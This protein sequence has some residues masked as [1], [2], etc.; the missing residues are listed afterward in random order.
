[1]HS[2]VARLR[3]RAISQATNST[4]QSDDGASS[5]PETP[6][7]PVSPVFP[8]SPDVPP[9]TAVD[10]KILPEVQ[11]L[12]DSFSV[13]DL[14]EHG[15]SPPPV[16]GRRSSSPALLSVHSLDAGP[17]AL[18][19]QDRSRSSSPAAHS[20]CSS[21]R[22]SKL[23]FSRFSR[24]LATSGV[25]STF[26][27]QHGGTSPRSSRID[28]Q[29]TRTGLTFG[30][31]DT[32]GIPRRSD[33]SGP[34]GTRTFGSS[35]ISEGRPSYASESSIALPATSYS[36]SF[37]HRSESHIITLDDPPHDRPP[38]PDTISSRQNSMKRSPTTQSSHSHSSHSPVA[39]VHTPLTTTFDLDF[40]SPQTFGQTSPLRLSAFTTS[41]N[42][43]ASA[44]PPP[45]MPPLSHPELVANMASRSQ[46]VLRELSTNIHSPPLRHYD[47]DL[48]PK[49]YPPRRRRKTDDDVPDENSVPFPE[50]RSR[51]SLRSYASLPKVRQLFQPDSRQRSK[52]S[53]PKST[54]SR[55]PSA[56]WNSQQATS[57]VLATN[58]ER[59]FGWPAE[60]SKEILR[61]SLGD[62]TIGKSR[63]IK[64]SLATTASSEPDII[65]RVRNVPAGSGETARPRLSLPSPHSKPTP[66][67]AQAEGEDKQPPTPPNGDKPLSW[68]PAGVAEV[69]RRMSAGGTS[70]LEEG[71]NHGHYSATLP[72]PAGSR[73][74]RKSILRH[75]NPNTQSQEAGPSSQQYVLS[76]PPRRS[77]ARHPARHSSE[78]A[79]PSVM[80]TPTNNKG[81]RK[82]EEIDITPPDQKNQHAKFILPVENKRVR[83]ISE[84]SGPP[85]AYQQRK[86]V[87]LSSSTSPAPTPG[88]SRPNSAQYGTADRNNPAVSPAVR[89]LSRAGSNRDGSTRSL[90][91]SI[92]SSIAPSVA[93]SRKG[94][95]RSP[96]QTS[97]PV[98]A[99][100]APHPPSLSRS[101]TYHMRDPRRPPRVHPT[102]WVPRVGSADEEGSSLHAW[103]FFAGFLLFPLWWI[104]SFLPIPE[105]RRVGYTDTE[106]GVT[107][108]DPQVEHDARTWRFRCRIMSVVALFTYI[109]FI[110]LVAIFAPR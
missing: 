93:D 75:S 25:W 77:G 103:I 44:S 86:R 45:P 90:R 58:G 46:P 40:S 28:Q 105:T 110:I 51:R 89:A 70:T 29:S 92:V 88:S 16:R 63:G 34:F 11:Q 95:R 91:Q 32:L 69:E 78:P 68:K 65:P 74:P 35:V 18:P 81:K 101:S 3:G 102:P 14:G 61:L 42:I 38:S 84:S 39:T 30:S 23:N 41:Q 80:E 36:S 24:R 27:R 48:Y 19:M 1:M 104:A 109:P 47:S 33:L 4:A 20:E 87:R 22:E 99:V 67:E 79:L 8:A 7:S 106:K 83:H 76:V 54:K 100:I 85:S 60:V 96:S 15:L 66:P 10:Q 55:R 64:T 5:R 12:M 82:A 31:V 13:I 59:D 6:V 37:Q 2:L 57:G 94:S 97:I 73:T 50:A 43:S 49:T 71:G 53:T 56:E 17:S 107:V 21:L 72:R 108:D 52:S 9:H 98:A 62:E 26:G